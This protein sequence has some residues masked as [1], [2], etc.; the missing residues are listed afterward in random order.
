MCIIFSGGAT[1]TSPPQSYI[2]LSE[3]T[4]IIDF[5]SGNFSETNFIPVLEIL[6]FPTGL[7]QMHTL[8]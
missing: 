1:N 3:R 7:F 8:W 2:E 6:K 5:W 4:D